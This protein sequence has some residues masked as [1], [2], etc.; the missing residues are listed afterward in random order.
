MELQKNKKIKA[1]R[2]DRDYK[3]YGRYDETGRNPRPFAIYLHEYGIN[4][5]FT[6]PRSMGSRFFCPSHTTRIV[7]LDR[8][9]YFEDDFGFDD[10]SGSRE[11][12]FKEENVFIPSVV[13]LDRNVINPVVDELVVGQDE[14][15]IE[16][17]AY[18]Q[19]VM[20]IFYHVDPSHVRK[21]IGSFGEAFKRHEQVFS[22]NLEK[23]QTW[24]D[25]LKEGSNL[26][27]WHLHDRNE[28]KFIKDLIVEVTSK[29]GVARLNIL[30]DLFGMESQ[31]EKLNFCV[32]NSSLD[33]ALDVRFIGICGMGGI[34][35]TTLARAY[36]EWMSPEFE[37]S[38][39]LANVREVCEK[40]NNGLVYLQ[41]LLLL[42][43]L[44]EES[45]K[46]RDTHRGKNIIKSRL[47]HKKVLI[48]LD[49]VD[50]LDQLK[51][52][53]E[54]DNWFGSGSRILI[55]TRDESLL[56]STYNDCKIYRAEELNDNEG[57]QLFSWKA[58]KSSHPSEDYTELSKQVIAYAKSLPLALEVLGSFLRGKT[59]NER[60]N[61]FHRL[62]K[63]PE[64]KIVKVLQI[65]GPNNKLWMHDLLQEM[66]REIVREKSRNEP[67]RW[68]R[69]W[70]YKDVYHVLKNNSA[71]EEVE[72][73]VCHLGHCWEAISKMKKLRL[74]ID[75]GRQ[76]G[77]GLTYLS[78]ELRILNWFL[79]PF[80]SLPSSFQPDGLVELKLLLSNINQ[81]WHNPIKNPPNPSKSFD[82]VLPGYEIPVWFTH[83][84]F[85]PSISLELDQNWCDSEWRG[86]GLSVFKGTDSRGECKVKIDGQDWGFGLVECPGF[87]RS[88][89][90]HL[91]VFYLP[92]N[93]Y[94]HTKWQKNCSTRLEF[95]F[96]NGW[97]NGSNRDNEY[98]CGVRLVCEQDI[99]DLSL[100]KEA[101]GFR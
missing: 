32:C 24:R 14:P 3:F 59:V 65:T 18:K 58:F 7:E 69:L 5:Q 11:P 89:N 31:L 55:T 54:K 53:A 78:N 76:M 51:V 79:F 20:P 2:S 88:S 80:A 63:N 94:F 90:H 74:L 98:G 87:F 56:I 95:T 86:F 67:G 100:H 10:S 34:G 8:A 97:G 33:G 30:E 70:D 96:D 83:R 43:I 44:N 50:K 13:F 49:D 36:Y 9:V 72:A 12:Q 84:S 101:G 71:T 41:N 1:V 62:K 23:V 28:A 91:W 57:L 17:E 46:I 39:F 40:E 75:S 48:V 42:D 64:K 19:I 26:A 45:T 85:V 15:I 60:E 27:G 81:L 37:C 77:G 52:L 73:I 99:Q 16:E 47:C 82:F 92:G 68:S 29:L 61:A 35:K 21:Q 25:A 6:M 22:H 93:I 4:A 66:G 38:S